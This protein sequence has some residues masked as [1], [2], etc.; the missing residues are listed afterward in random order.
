MSESITQSLLHLEERLLMPSVRRSSSELSQLLAEDFREIGRDGHLYT[1]EEII[2]ILADE[3]PTGR[4]LIIDEFEI[5]ELAP[6][7]VLVTYRLTSGAGYSRRS[8]IWRREESGWR[9]VFH[10]G[11]S[12]G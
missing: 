7:L 10:Q 6:G 3:V 4:S 2:S 11:T 12:A 9:M 1:R 8:S 5:S